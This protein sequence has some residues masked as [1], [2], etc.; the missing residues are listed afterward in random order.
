MH[1]AMSA[2]VCGDLL[3]EVEMAGGGECIGGSIGGA[4][5]VAL[6]QDRY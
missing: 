6:L 2:V 5:M 4:A 1:A 3:V